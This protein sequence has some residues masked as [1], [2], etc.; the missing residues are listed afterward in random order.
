MNQLKEA[1][2]SR[3]TKK[4]LALIEIP[5]FMKDVTTTFA[6]T[7]RMDLRSI[8]GRLQ[9]LGWKSVELDDSTLQMI[10]FACEYCDLNMTTS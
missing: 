6:A 5:L 10:V 7:P 4:G 1:L 8:N 9:V 3:L 2:L